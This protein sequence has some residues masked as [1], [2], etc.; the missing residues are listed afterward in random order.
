MKL[1]VL[2]ER[3]PARISRFLWACV[4]LAF[5]LY[6]AP[7]NAGGQEIPRPAGRFALV[8]G[9]SDY[10]HVDNLPNTANDASDI[11]EKLSALGYSV[12][13][14]LNADSG[15]M[16]R[17]VGDWI[18][19]LSAERTSEGFFWYAGHG[20]QVSGENY[21]LPVDINAED[22]AGIVYGSYPLGR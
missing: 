6:A 13:L 14:R 2:Y 11:A 16:A 20:V 21:L 1:P 17:A 12:D 22:E 4:F 10:R 3:P 5:I 18:R 8:I 15:A 19:R 7:Q 9:N